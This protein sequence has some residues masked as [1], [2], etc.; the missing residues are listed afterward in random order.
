MKRRSIAAIAFLAINFPT[1]LLLRARPEPYGWL[2]DGATAPV[3]ASGRVPDQGQQGQEGE[4]YSVK[5]AMKMASF[6]LVLLANAVYS[7]G[8]STSHVH[9]IPHLRFTGFTELLPRG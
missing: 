2:P 7:F 4:S 8:T 5:D 1:A 9:F 3:Q 6:W